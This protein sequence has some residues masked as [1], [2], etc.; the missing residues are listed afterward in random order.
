MKYRPYGDARDLYLMAVVGLPALIVIAK[1]MIS[2]AK[3]WKLRQQ[4]IFL[5]TKYNVNET[6]SFEDLIRKEGRQSDALGSGFRFFMSCLVIMSLSAG[7]FYLIWK[8]HVLFDGSQELTLPVVCGLAHLCL[9]F[10]L[11]TVSVYRRYVVWRVIIYGLAGALFLN[12]NFIHLLFVPGAGAGD[13]V[14]PA[15]V[16]IGAC[17]FFCTMR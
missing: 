7:I 14:F 17:W 2:E 1:I 8:D 5:S 4:Q 12:I 6:G 13:F 15:V 9:G 3:E 16:L 10:F 11:F